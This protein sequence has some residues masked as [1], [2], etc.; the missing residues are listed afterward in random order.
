MQVTILAV[1][2]G[3][4][5]HVIAV[6][7]NVFMRADHQLCAAFPAIRASDIGT[8]PL[9]V[10]GRPSHIPPFA[11]QPLTT[12]RDGSMRAWGR[13]SAAALPVMP[14]PRTLEPS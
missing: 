8:D 7:V 14:R 4:D 6:G 11:R 13:I 3:Q 12:H 1:R 9:V 10:G 2:Q 5:F